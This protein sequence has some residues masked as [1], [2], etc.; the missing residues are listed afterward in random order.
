MDGAGECAL[1]AVCKACHKTVVE[2]SG[3]AVVV[4]IVVVVSG[5]GI[6]GHVAVELVA[7][8]KPQV[9]VYEPLVCVDAVVVGIYVKICPIG[10]DE[11]VERLCIPLQGIAYGGRYVALFGCP[12]LHAAEFGRFYRMELRA[13]Y[14]GRR[15][16][17]VLYV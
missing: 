10:V 1:G 9:G 7:E 16:H 6:Y 3:I 2:C 13:R 14:Y 8:V 5:S 4:V 12:A 15:C 17:A 11:R